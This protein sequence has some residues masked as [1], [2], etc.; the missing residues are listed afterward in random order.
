MADIASLSGVARATLYNHFRTKE[1]V[2]AALCEHEVREL[3]AECAAAPDLAAALSRAAERLAGHPAVRRVA[4]DHDSQP[5]EPAALA[6][7]TGLG[8]GPVWTL[9]RESAVSVLAGHG[10]AAD[11]AAAEMALRW[12]VSHAAAPSDAATISRGAALLAAGLAAEPV[13][14]EPA[15]VTAPTRTVSDFGPAGATATGLS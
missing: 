8:A 4:G 6:E 9:A 12:V 2:Y 1:A 5:A 3:A 14:A 10:T 7:L 11:P 13:S 15:G